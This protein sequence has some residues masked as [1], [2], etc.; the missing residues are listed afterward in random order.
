[1]VDEQVDEAVTDEVS[2]IDD[3]S[4]PAE[5]QTGFGVGPIADGKDDPIVDEPINEWLQSISFDSTAEV[6]IPDTRWLTKSL[7]KKMHHS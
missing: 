1:M 4:Q 7:V 6:P 5:E 2:V 3:V